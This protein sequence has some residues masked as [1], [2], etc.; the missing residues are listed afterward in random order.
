[1]NTP[2]AIAIAYLLGAVCYA[3]AMWIYGRDYAKKPIDETTFYLAVMGTLVWPLT[4]WVI[5]AVWAIDNL[6]EHINKGK[7]NG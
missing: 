5:F 7:D 2:T 6:R 1:M 4:V 3:I